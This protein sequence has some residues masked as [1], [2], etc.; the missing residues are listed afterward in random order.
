MVDHAQPSAKT[1]VFISYSRDDLVF[2]DQLDAVLKFHDFATTLDRHG[3][4]GGEDWKRRLGNLIRDADTV[5][6]VLSPSSARSDICGWEVEEAAH[7]GKR[8]IPVVCRPLEDV[9]APARLSELNY[10]HFFSDPRLPGSGFGT[11]QVTLINALN[12]DID[13]LREHTRYLQR[14]VEWQSGGRAVNRL[15][16]GDGIAAAKAWATRRPKDAPEPTAVHL[17]FIRASEHAELER[18]DAAKKQLEEMEAAQTLKAEALAQREAALTTLSRRTWLGAAAAGS[19]TAVAGGLAYWAMQAEQRFAAEQ[20]ERK[21]AEANSEH[22]AIRREAMR[23]DLVGQLTAFATAPGMTALAGHENDPASPYTDTVIAQLSKDPN[24]SL[25]KALSRSN[26]LVMER[27]SFRQRPYLSSDMNGEI[28]F[29]MQPPSR[30]KL[31]LVVAGSDFVGGG[32][33]RPSKVNQRDADVWAAYLKTC[34]FDVQSLNHVSSAEVRSAL[35]SL[36][37]REVAQMPAA[38]GLAPVASSHAHPNSL[39]VFVFAGFGASI[40]NIPYVL[41]ADAE[42][43]QEDNFKTLA[44]TSFAVHDIQKLAKDVAAASV[45]FLD[46]DL[47][48]PQAHAR[49]NTK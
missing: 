49:P 25:F 35:W 16:S 43:R 36:A 40:E 38:G 19:L 15:L 24:N 44:S 30:Q 34:D 37:R 21:K 31:A 9:A 47:D 42:V 27:T 20:W 41:M 22:E 17:E 45:I 32:P 1:T 28:Y 18:T 2:A 10:I 4:S 7:L 14:A 29:K 26:A 48:D 6:F 3:I 33:G 46:A 23:T 13:W 39:L 12:T 11:G 8:I 5:V